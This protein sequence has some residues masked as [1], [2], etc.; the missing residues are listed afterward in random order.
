MRIEEYTRDLTGDGYLVVGSDHDWNSHN[1]SQC[2]PI[3]MSLTR[4][5]LGKPYGIGLDELIRLADSD[6]FL[7]N[8]TTKKMYPEFRKYYAE[9]VQGNRSDRQLGAFRVFYGGIRL[10]YGNRQTGE[11]GYLWIAGAELLRLTFET[12]RTRLGFKPA[13]HVRIDCYSD[14]KCDTEVEEDLGYLRR[15]IHFDLKDPHK[16][17]DIFH[18]DNQVLHIFEYAGM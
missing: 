18:T 17:T 10:Y 8:E 14:G 2:A 7:N 16:K 9:I 12:P 1:S 15:E 4:L 6:C 11:T 5:P 3:K 13:Y